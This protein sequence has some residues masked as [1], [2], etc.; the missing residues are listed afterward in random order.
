MPKRKR[1]PRFLKGRKRKRR[2]RIPRSLPTIVPRKHICKLRYHNYGGSVNP[3]V[4]TTGALVFTCNGLADPYISGGGHQPR[5]FDQWMAFYEKYTVVSA[6]ITT[7]FVC[8]GTGTG[9]LHQAICGIHCDDNA[10]LL[11]TDVRYYTE[12]AKGP[13]TV[14]GWADGSAAIRTLSRKISIKKYFNNKSMLNEAQFVGTST[15][16]PTDQVYFHVYVGP[17]VP[18]DDPIAVTCDNHIEYVVVF[19]ERRDFALDSL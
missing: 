17:L 10:T 2:R 19:H 12:L 16:N 15:T 11:N 13:H 7:R 6:K 4:G 14:L 18:S 9:G 8:R 3:G 1:A 5:G